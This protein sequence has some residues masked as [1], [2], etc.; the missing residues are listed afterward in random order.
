MFRTTQIYLLIIT[1]AESKANNH[2]NS[3]YNIVLMDYVYR[4]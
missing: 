3:N 1:D 4:K 2:A